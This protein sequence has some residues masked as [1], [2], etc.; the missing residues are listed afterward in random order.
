MIKL[1]KIIE[2]L[3]YLYIFILPWQT[4]W[5]F[6]EGIIN[7]N[8]WQYG[9]MVLFGS[10]ILLW[11]IIILQLVFWIKS[12]QIR[13]RDLG[14]YGNKLKLVISLWLVVVFGGLSIFWSSDKQLAFYWWFHLLEAASL[15][16]I[17][18]NIK[19]DF[20]KISWVFLGAG[21]IQSLLAFGQF[22]VQKIPANKWLGI[23]SHLPY[24]LG[25]IVIE[26]SQG[27]DHYRWLRAYGSFNHPNVLGG[28]LVICFFLALFLY[29]KYRPGWFKVVSALSLLIIFIGIFFSFSRSAW[30]ALIIAFVTC[31]AF[32]VL[33]SK[34]KV[35]SITKITIYTFCVFILLFIIYTPLVTTRLWQNDRLEIKSTQERLDSLTGAKEIINDNFWQGTGIGHY[36]Y[37]LYQKNPNLQAWDYQPVHNIYFL[38]WAELGIIGFVIFMFSCLFIFVLLVKNIKTNIL[39]I[40]LLLTLLIIGLFDHYLWTSYFGL[41]LWWLIL[42]FVLKL[43]YFKNES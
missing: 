31:Y 6:Y 37:E 42:G 22:I 29:I 12:R 1:K 25:A 15:F 43:N 19:I 32:H 36:T 28:F 33:R 7:G 18:I 2:Y 11:L 40:T 20:K 10:E 21:I 5:I 3:L 13:F 24:D 30:L 14:I 23:A 39:G 41:I 16:F 34:D 4:M 27:T 9:T 38:I 8:K 17:V 26:Y 35:L